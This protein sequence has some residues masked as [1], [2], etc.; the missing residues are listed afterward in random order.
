M[1]GAAKDATG[2]YAI[3]LMA[4]RRGVLPSVRCAARARRALVMGRWQA[5]AV[6]QVGYLL[7]QER[8]VLAAVR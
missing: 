4:V 1:L 7:L 2:T 5:G 3:G 8:F 6:K